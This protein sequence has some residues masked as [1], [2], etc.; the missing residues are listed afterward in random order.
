M[1]LEARNTLTVDLRKHIQSRE[2]SPLA[3]DAKEAA[4]QQ[5]VIDQMNPGGWQLG[6]PSAYNRELALYTSD[7]LAYVKTTHTGVER[8][9]RAG[10]RRTVLA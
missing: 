10:G 1:V 5:D 7:C 3:A 2:G 9:T 4:F 6:K 8:S